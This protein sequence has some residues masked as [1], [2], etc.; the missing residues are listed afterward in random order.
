MPQTENIFRQFATDRLTV[1]KLP[2]GSTA[3]FDERSKSVHSLNPSATIV[4]NACAGGA[5]FSQVTAAL[6]QHRGPSDEQTALQA[7]VQLQQ[8][9]LVT[10]ETPIAGL[11]IDM[12]RRS[13]LKSVGSLGA[14]A[15]PLVLT[16][17][18]AE[19]RAYAQQAGSRTT[20]APTTTIAVRSDIRLKEDIRLLTRLF[21]LNVYTFR[22]FGSPNLRVGLLA[23]EVYERFPEAVVQGGADPH[24]QPW[25]IDYAV[26]VR[27]ISHRQAYVLQE[28]AFANS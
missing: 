13:I 6:V 5:T 3:I 21:G 16:L 25:K 22:F 27:R 14:M 2:D 1:E 26:L 7:I 4:W 17:T 9:G 12:E 10:A 24:T 11:Q 23:Q 28:L 8:A 20:P 15:A 18:S 19:Q